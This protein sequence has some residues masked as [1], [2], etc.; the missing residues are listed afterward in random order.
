MKILLFN[1]TIG[2]LKKIDLKNKKFGSNE[3]NF[4]F[5]FN[6]KLYYDNEGCINEYDKKT[7]NNK[8]IFKPHSRV[9][10]GLYLKNKLYFPAINGKV[11]EYDLK[12][13]NNE[14]VMEKM[15]FLVNVL[16]LKINYILLLWVMKFMNIIQK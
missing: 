1:T 9:Y 13:K 8:I 6:D 12:T 3:V 2:I 4:L 14:V 16:Y 10:S 11:Y 7:N 5:T 15:L